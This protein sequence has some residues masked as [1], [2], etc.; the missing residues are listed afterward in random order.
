MKSKVLIVVISACLTLTAMDVAS[1]GRGL[2]H[3]ALDFGIL[4]ADD[5]GFLTVAEVEVA[6]KAHF[7]VID[8]DGN[9]SLSVDELIAARDGDAIDRAKRMVSSMDANDDGELQANE[10]MRRGPDANNVVL[11]A[12]KNNDGKIS[13]AE[14]EAVIKHRG[15]YNYKKGHGHKGGKG[16][17]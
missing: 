13:Q 11:R 4:D 5:S 15:D 12:D 7:D 9:G 6:G 14:F 8:I 2:R 10:M 3:G 1:Q 16:R 17:G